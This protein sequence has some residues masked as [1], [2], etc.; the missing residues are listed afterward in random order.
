MRLLACL[1]VVLLATT[2]GPLAAQAPDSVWRAALARLT[3]GTAVRL[4]SRDRG[5]I[6][7]RLVGIW[8]TTLNLETGA[9]RTE[10]STAT[11]DSLWVRRTNAKTGA[12]IGAIPGAVAGGLMGWIAN[13]VACTEGDPCPEAIPLGGLAGAAA[14]AILGGLVGS[15]IPKWQRRVP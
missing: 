1:T 4:H 8:G 11:I 9:T 15:L 5:R 13:E 3:P 2:I 7:G 14:G 12:I 6:E 10:W